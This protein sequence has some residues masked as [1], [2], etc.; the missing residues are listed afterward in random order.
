MT[1]IEHY[2]RYGDEWAAEMMKLTKARILDMLRPTLKSLRALADAANAWNDAA[3]VWEAAKSTPG[4][5][6]AEIAYIQSGISLALEAAE[7]RRH[8]D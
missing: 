7:A 3:D 1:E 5:S 4:E 2:E 8:Y 6:A